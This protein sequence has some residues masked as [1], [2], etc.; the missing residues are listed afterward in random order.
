MNRNTFDSLPWIKHAASYLGLKEI[1][2][3]RHAPEITKMLAELGLP[4]SDDE[5]PWCA[6]FC[7]AMLKR[8]KRGYP[9]QSPAWARS[10]DKNGMKL[11]KPAF[12]ATATKARKGGGGHVY[13]IVGITENG[14]IV[15]LGGN[16]S[17][18]VNLALFRPSEVTSINWPP[19]E[20]GVVR[21]PAEFRYDLPRY[22]SRTLKLS[23]SEA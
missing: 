2:G 5:T 9:K 20:D 12:G 13:F 7:S 11:T 17:D 10:F 6:V 23:A 22:N 14:M 19:S 1:K 21:A 8:A 15:G 4:W 16:Q 3:A 18:S